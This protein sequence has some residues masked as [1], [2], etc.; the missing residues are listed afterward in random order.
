MKKLLFVIAMWLSMMLIIP[1]QTASILIDTNSH[2]LKSLTK[3]KI[4]D[5]LTPLVK[6]KIDS[7]L[8]LNIK[9]DKPSVTIKD[10]R[11]N[12]NNSKLF[13]SNNKIKQSNVALT[14]SINNYIHILENDHNLQQTKLNNNLNN[15]TY[16][17][18][19]SRSLDINKQ[20]VY[21]MLIY[22]RN[23]KIWAIS[24]GLLVFFAYKVQIKK[25]TLPIYY[26]YLIQFK[27][28]ISGIL[29]AYLFYWLFTFL[30][31]YNWYILTSLSK[32]G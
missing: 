16:I 12:F 3:D 25:T 9:F 6:H 1:A 4:N 31:N 19:I 20:A 13:E 18:F 8:T 26:F 28:L 2:K 15:E 5:K 11:N 14:K 10:T 7:I 17:E 27:Y 21:N 29:T 24:I 23:L 30:F 22:R 32:F